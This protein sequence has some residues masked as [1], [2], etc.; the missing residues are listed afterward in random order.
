MRQIANLLIGVIRSG[1]S[2]PLSFA[3]DPSTYARE[4]VAKIS[5]YSYGG[6]SLTGKAVVLKTTSSLAR[7]VSVRVRAPPPNQ[8][9]R[10]A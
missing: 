6:V 1:G 5:L 9:G 7:G 2:N 4:S 10:V 3:I 8:Y